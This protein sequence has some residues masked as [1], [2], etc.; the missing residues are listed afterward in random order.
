MY[1][2][3]IILAMWDLKLLCYGHYEKCPHFKMFK[4]WIYT[5]DEGCN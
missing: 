3:T 2:V 5:S 4:A 1:I